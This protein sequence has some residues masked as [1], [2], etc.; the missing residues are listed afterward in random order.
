[1]PSNIRVVKT[2]DSTKHLW[3]LENAGS[4]PKV[5]VPQKGLLQTLLL[6]TWSLRVVFLSQ[7]FKAGHWRIFLISLTS[8]TRDRGSVCVRGDVLQGIF[9]PGISWTTRHANELQEQS[10]LHSDRIYL[11]IRV[12]RTEA[13]MEIW[14]GDLACPRSH[15]TFPTKQEHLLPF[16]RICWFVH[17]LWYSL[18]SKPR[19]L[20]VT[21]APCFLP[22]FKRDIDCYN[23]WKA[24]GWT[25]ILWCFAF[26]LSV[27]VSLH[28]QACR[29]ALPK[30]WQMAVIS[31]YSSHP[32]DWSQWKEKILFPYVLKSQGRLPLVN[33]YVPGCSLAHLDS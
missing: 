17:R 27:L 32:Q 24:Q 30:W 8:E 26:H 33:S 5:M 3:A 12:L 19:S 6:L 25:P 23:N 14:E 29:Q 28:W 22:Y 1:M 7:A 31:D 9:F 4:M 15:N 20:Q 13:E 11:S 18:S 2:G 10:V 21:E 16:N